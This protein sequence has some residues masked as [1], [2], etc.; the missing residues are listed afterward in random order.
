MTLGLATGVLAGCQAGRSNGPITAPA[1]R[2][3][4][5]STT[6]TGSLIPATTSP[7]VTEPAIG[8]ATLR[9]I[10]LGPADLPPG[11]APAAPTDT[12]EDL[13][14]PQPCGHPLA[15]AATATAAVTQVLLRPRDH[16]RMVERLEG[17]TRAGAAA[18]PVA[19]LR[20][21][22]HECHHDGATTVTPIQPPAVG[23]EVAG[24]QISGAEGVVVVAAVR[25]GPIVTFIALSA[26]GPIP[27]ATVRSIVQAAG[28][29][30]AVG[31]GG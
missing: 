7:L 22:A 29:K 15:D 14:A 17:F 19:A 30:L 26:P 18:L 25:S 10:L 23:E 9:S 27:A 31:T 8:T 11:F 20:A 21:L 16:L 24:L 5:A 3:P 28:T 12:G 4:Y 1:R 2:A 6:T 13:L